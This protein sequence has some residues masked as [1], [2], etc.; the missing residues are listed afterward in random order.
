MGEGAFVGPR[1]LQV[2]MPDG[3]KRLVQGTKI[4][5]GVGTRSKLDAT[6]GLA[7]SRPMTH[8][9]ALELDVVPEHLVVVGAGYIGLEFT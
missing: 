5:I 3:T 2:S 6:P 9:E 4:V 8:V 7:E 1:L